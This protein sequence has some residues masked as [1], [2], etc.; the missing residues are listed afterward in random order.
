[1]PG[2]AIDLDIIIMEN[3]PLIKGRLSVVTTDNAT[4][5]DEIIEI[6]INKGHKEIGFIN[7]LAEAEISVIR[8]NAYKKALEKWGITIKSHY[9]R[10]ADFLEVK[11]YEEAKIL[12]IKNPSITAIFCASD[13]M[14]IGVYKALGELGKSIP[15]DIAVVGFDGIQISEYVTPKLTTVVQDFRGMVKKAV[16]KVIAQIN[17]EKHEPIS[18]VPYQIR[19]RDSI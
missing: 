17:G 13:L 15:E 2:V 7:G 19:I 10:Y 11:A 12:V 3:N 14:A 1:V 8:E 16:E 6:L 9:I 5:I 18:Y 4:A